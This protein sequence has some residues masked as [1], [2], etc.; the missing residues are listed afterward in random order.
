MQLRGIKIIV[1]GGASGLG[2]ACAEGFAK[3]GAE[4]FIADRDKE[5]GAKAATDP[6]ITF[7]HAD[8]TDA[9]SVENLLDQVADGEEPARVLL[10]CAGVA[11]LLSLVRNG[12]PHCLDAFDHVLKTNITGTFLPITRF[13]MRLKNIELLG[14]EKGVI[15]NTSSITA[16]EGQAGHTAYA[17]TK[18]AINAMTLPLARELAINRIR[19]VAIA[20]G[21]FETPMLA[22]VPTS[23]KVEL[24][25]QVPHPSRLGLPEEF[26][27]LARH[28]IENSYINGEVIRLDG[29]LRLVHS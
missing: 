20:P 12:V 18:G 13:A 3:K 5:A 22:N 25:T 1:T 21:P 4:V 27:S 19:V 26:A 15:I 11:P 9:E 6:S 2:L 8:V 14:E 7:V 28:V 24:G 10:N 17:A 16:F 23:S 29:G